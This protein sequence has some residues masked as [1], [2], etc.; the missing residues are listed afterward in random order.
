MLSGLVAAAAAMKSTCYNSCS[1]H[2]SCDSLDRCTCFAG[3]FGADCSRRRC[4]VGRN[5]FGKAKA[6][7]SG[8]DAHSLAVNMQMC[9]NAGVCNFDTGMCSCFD[10]Y[11]GDACDQRKCVSETSSPTA[12]GGTCS[13]HGACKNMLALGREYGPDDAVT[14]VPLYDGTG[15][16]YGGWE[17][18]MQYGC[19]CDHGWT[20]AD[21]SARL[22]PYG[23]MADTT[24]QQRPAYRI[25]V[26][27]SDV[28][29]VSKRGLRLRFA[30][31]TS[32]AT[33]SFA[34]TPSSAACS[35]WLAS[36]PAFNGSDTSC[37]VTANPVPSPADGTVIGSAQWEL[38]ISVAFAYE[39]GMNNFYFYRGT[40]APSMFS[41]FFYPAIPGLTTLSTSRCTVSSVD[42]SSMTSVSA[43]PSAGTVYYVVVTD[44]TTL[45]NKFRATRTV[46]G[47]PPVST[48]F[49][50]LDMTFNPSGIDV[51]DGTTVKWASAAGHTLAAQWTIASTGVTAASYREYEMCGR[52]GVCD[53]VNGVCQCV[54]ATYGGPACD[55]LVTAQ[56]GRPDDADVKPVLTVE[57]SSLTY[58]SSALLVTSRRPQASVFQYINIAD[59]VGPV[60]TVRG[61]GA[62]LLQSIAASARITADAGVL[63]RMTSTL[64]STYAGYPP[65]D[66]QYASSTVAPSAGVVRVRSDIG[67]DS[68][69]P[70]PGSY[71]LLSVAAKTTTAG[72]LYTNLVTVAG[73]GAATFAAGITVTDAPAASTV[74]TVISSGA[75]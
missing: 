4:P 56:T 8:A 30:G 47:S 33:L 62:V 72:A 13:G 31:Q 70:T 25:L 57:A 50:Q 58:A 11:T 34:T 54:S 7:N 26:D 42:V 44:T 59:P 18:A 35:A 63:A 66:V 46:A 49:P 41:C 52:A 64:A 15:L 2:G 17:S 22:C 74:S 6:A 14:S 36:I 39:S 3:Y 69:S 20:G 16:T 38:I 37:A 75:S 19:V 23:D 5:W 12:F 61:D 1:G 21:C 53:A 73:S 40:P 43:L 32:S 24:N 28:S 60:F 71:N 67:L 65:L 51:G 55:Q 27:F 68:S 10:G 29:D 45:P 48:T 9:S